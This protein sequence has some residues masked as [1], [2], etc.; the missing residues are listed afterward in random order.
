MGSVPDEP[1]Q[2]E[3]A[4]H[5]DDGYRQV[6]RF[7][8]VFS[9]LIG[10]MY[11][12]AWPRMAVLGPTIRIRPQVVAN[13]FFANCKR[14]MPHDT[15]EAR[16]S[17]ALQTR[18]DGAIELRRAVAHWSWEVGYWSRTGG[19]PGAAPTAPFAV[20]FLEDAGMGWVGQRLEV[21]L[22]AQCDALVTVLHLVGQYGNVCYEAHGRQIAGQVLRVS[23]VL[24]LDENGEPALGPLALAIPPSTSGM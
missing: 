3:I 21:D 10:R 24:V 1:S 7:M 2:A 18:V 12:P 19:V 15:A 16:A 17:K 9:Q 23:D 8:V 4:A 6:G 22:D 11:N 20:P 14:K 5:R 13:E